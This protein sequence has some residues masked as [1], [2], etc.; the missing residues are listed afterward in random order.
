M[1]PLW[2]VLCVCVATSDHEGG[3]PTQPAASASGRGQAGL[4][5][6]V[7]LGEWCVRVLVGEEGVRVTGAPH[8]MFGGSCSASTTIRFL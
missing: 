1:V 7:G 2:G 8:E 3:A 5:V 4:G 6:W